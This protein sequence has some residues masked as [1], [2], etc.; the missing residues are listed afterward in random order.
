MAQNIIFK[1]KGIKE[2]LGDPEESL[3]CESAKNHSAVLMLISQ[4][5]YRRCWG[6]G[7]VPKFL[8]FL[9]SQ[10]PVLLPQA[11]PSPPFLILH[12]HFS[13]EKGEEQL[14]SQSLPEC[15]SVRFAAASPVAQV[16]LFLQSLHSHMLWELKEGP[17]S[18]PLLLQRK[19]QSECLTHGCLGFGAAHKINPPQ[20]FINKW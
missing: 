16:N 20:I 8:I 19:K 17:G 5:V 13:L 10:W 6:P 14:Q 2:V 7:F 3:L 12:S 9:H 4:A 1:S 18:V 15:L 11:Q